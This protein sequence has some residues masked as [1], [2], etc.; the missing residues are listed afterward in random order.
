MIFVKVV[1]K[2]EVVDLYSDSRSNET[3]SAVGIKKRPMRGAKKPPSGGPEVALLRATT[4]LRGLLSYL[5][6]DH[7]NRGYPQPLLA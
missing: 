4:A 3:T 5:S 2:V 6:L 7:N 1:P